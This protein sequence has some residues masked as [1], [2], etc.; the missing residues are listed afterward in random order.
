[1]RA[2]ALSLSIFLF[3]LGVAGCL[4]ADVAN[5]TLMCS[6]QPGRACPRGFYC[7][8]NNY[9]YHDGEGPGATPRP[10]MSVVYDFAQPIRDFA[11]QPPPSD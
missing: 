2:V 4:E 8:N 11:T 6:K 5:G 3:S 10:D 7:A 9:C 1:M